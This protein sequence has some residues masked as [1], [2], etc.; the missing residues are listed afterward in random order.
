MELV[1]TI[2]RLLLLSQSPPL[3]YFVKGLSAVIPCELLAVF[4]AHEAEAML[5]G[6][7]QVDVDV[8]K[9]ATIYESIS[10]T[11]RCVYLA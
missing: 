10:P 9:K 7:A 5:C 1:E 8:L 2:Q 4:S 6:Q 11:D 3:T